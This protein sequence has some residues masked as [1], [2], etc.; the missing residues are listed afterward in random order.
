MDLLQ[1][2][3]LCFFSI[4]HYLHSHKI[5]THGCWRN[6]PLL[7]SVCWPGLIWNQF[8]L[9]VWYL[10]SQ[11]VN[12]LHSQGLTDRRV[13]LNLLRYKPSS[14]FYIRTDSD[15]LANLF[16][17]VISLAVWTF[18]CCFN[19]RFFFIWWFRGMTPAEAEMNFLENAKK[20]SMYGVDLHH[21]KVHHRSN[22]CC[23]YF[24][25]D[26]PTLFLIYNTERYKTS[27]SLET[28][29]RGSFSLFCCFVYVAISTVFFERFPVVFFELN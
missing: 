12:K 18:S 23:F 7:L 15:P 16:Y 27:G 20:L 19:A 9:F 28:R 14:W 11:T 2:L 26:C 25:F 8:R 1:N 13:M 4:I 24:R 10:L 21:A 22:F 3:C 29:K 6:L 17:S 5:H